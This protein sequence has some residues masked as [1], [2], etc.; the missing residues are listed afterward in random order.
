MAD[1]PFSTTPNPAYDAPPSIEFLE[2][3]RHRVA[4]I[5]WGVDFIE[6]ADLVKT[7]ALDRTELWPS[8]GFAPMPSPEFR[9]AVDAFA[10]GL[11]DLQH[12]YDAQENGDVADR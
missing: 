3:L 6:T 7:I 8:Y 12:A 2:E 4:K 9:A 11:S 10:K 1:S 5:G